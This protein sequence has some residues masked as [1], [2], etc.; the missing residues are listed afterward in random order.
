MPKA[1]KDHSP[2]GQA[3]DTPSAPRLR[4]NKGN[5]DVLPQGANIPNPG[6]INVVSRMNQGT[7]HTTTNSGGGRRKR[8][9]GY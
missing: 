7:H 4:E 8:G 1:V 9:R 5:I 3:P 2:A 6:N